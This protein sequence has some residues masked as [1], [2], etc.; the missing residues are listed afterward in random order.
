M[1]PW[2]VEATQVKVA[3]EKKKADEAEKDQEKKA[4]DETW[5]ADM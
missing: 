3:N 5:V 1:Y 2:C 4:A